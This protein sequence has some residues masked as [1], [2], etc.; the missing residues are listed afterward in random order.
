[1]SWVDGFALYWQKKKSVARSP[2]VSAQMLSSFSTAVDLKRQSGWDGLSALQGHAVAHVRNV[3]PAPANPAYTV[4]LLVTCTAL[5]QDGYSR[6]PMTHST[7]PLFSSQALNKSPSTN[8]APV[9]AVLFESLS[10]WSAPTSIS[11]SQ[12]VTR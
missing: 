9:P 4:E 6:F 7:F 5:Q 1:M 12:R 8:H 10:L 11:L 3:F 2:F